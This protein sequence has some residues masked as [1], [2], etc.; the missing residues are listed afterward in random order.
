MTVGEVVNN[1]RS[2]N[3]L[4]MQEFADRCGLSKAYISMVEKGKH[5]QNNRKLVPNLETLA[6][7][8]KGM[9]TDINTFLSVLDLDTIVSVNLQNNHDDLPEELTVLS[10][11]WETIS[12]DDKAIIKFIADKYK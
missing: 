10:S 11:A 3:H 9:D 6:K 8:A 5:P 4:T 2:S 1:Y 7:L 12:A